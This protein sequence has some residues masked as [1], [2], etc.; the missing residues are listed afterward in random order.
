[1]LDYSRFEVPAERLRWTCDPTTL[2]FETTVELEPMAEPIGQQRAMAAVDFGANVPSHGY[3]IFVLGPV[4]AGRSTMTRQALAAIA[5]EQPTPSDWCYAYNFSDPRAPVAIELAA[6]DGRRLANDV[7]E[8][9]EDVTQAI[10]NAF[11]SEEYQN[12]RDE[13]LKE[14][15]EERHREMRE[16]EQE[17]EK[18]GLTIGR[19]PGGLVVAPARDGEVMSPQDYD[20]LEDEERQALDKKREQLQDK[21][22]D[23][24]QDL[25][26]REKEARKALREL[27]RQTIQFATG[28]LIDELIEEYREYDAVIEHLEQMKQDLV[29]NVARFRDGEEHTPPFPIPDALLS[30]EHV[31][32]DRY[33][34]NAL[35]GHDDGR[36]APVVFEMNPTIDNLTGEIEYQTRMGALVT[37]FTMIKPGALHKA[38]GG[39]LL[40]EAEAVLR[41]PYAW[42][43]LK[44]CLKNGQVRVE[45]IQDQLR[46]IS[47]VS[48]EPQPIPLNVKVVLIGTPLIYYLL[49]I[50]DDEFSKLFK[51]KAD[52]NVTIDRSEET[53]REYARFIAAK[54]Q[55]EELPAFSAAA[56][57][58]VVEYGVRT[59]AD[60]EKLTTRFG[61][62]VDLVREASYWATR[63]GH[64]EVVQPEDVDYAIEQHIW[65]SNRIEEQL[66][67]MIQQGTLMIDTDGAAVGQINALQVMQ[68]GDYMIGMPNRITARSFMGS[69]GVVNIEREA[70]LSGPVHNKGVLI[71]SGYLGQKYATEQPL[72]CAASISFEQSYSQVEGDSASCAEL[73]ALL[74]SLSGIALRQD[75]AVTGSI[76]QHGM[77]QPI[78][79]VTRKIEGFF[80][81]CKI[82]GL[83]GNQ[84]VV[85]PASNVRH[86]VLREEVVAAVEQ[87]KFHVWAVETVDEVLGILTGRPAGQADAQG[88]YPKGTVH[89]AVQDR[90]KELAEA[91]KEYGRP[92]GGKGRGE[93]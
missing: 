26:R 41:R 46:L 44:R 62:V 25:R 27:D 92:Q 3:N 60:Q 45:S 75:I 22:V 93:D 70:K 10:E 38:N 31:P 63:N 20:A 56:V 51:V 32:Y 5:A 66:L 61:P 64:R 40:L 72:S 7:D 36:G 71:L 23:L 15:R 30:G 17:A 90:L 82:K 88:N 74:S 84:G 77:I 12:Q 28:H 89:Q 4:A 79:G 59:A 55:E 54:C 24:M 69:N 76:N 18:A 47:T 6:G 52:F 14:F 42:E 34:I 67:E 1:V 21:L 86:L 11:E 57:A 58:K 19:S 37:D 91:F 65:R 48:L 73:V 9:I 8:L 80:Y 81:A 35:V 53:I 29:E 85:I 49:H 16:F 2:D 43:A 39:Y 78:G 68:F 33:R 83:T 50:Y 87:G 13:L